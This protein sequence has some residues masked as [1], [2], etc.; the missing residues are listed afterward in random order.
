[1]EAPGAACERGEN[2]ITGAG[3]AIV[4]VMRGRLSVFISLGAA[5]AAGRRAVGAVV[6]EDVVERQ[7]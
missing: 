4:E 5:A 2:F 6:V 7:R 3:I 1:M